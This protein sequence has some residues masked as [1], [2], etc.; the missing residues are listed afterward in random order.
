MGSVW[1]CGIYGKEGDRRGRK[2]AGMDGLSWLRR[3]SEDAGEA[4]SLAEHGSSGTGGSLCDMDER[5][6]ARDHRDQA[7]GWRHGLRSG[8]G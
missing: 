5:F 7:A 4:I 3:K 1:E 8:A 6:V 2:I